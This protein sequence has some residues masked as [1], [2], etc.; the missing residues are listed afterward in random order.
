VSGGPYVI[1]MLVD[2]A[3][4]AVQPAMDGQPVEV[5]VPPGSKVLEVPSMTPDTY[6][7]IGGS[8][9]VSNPGILVW[10]DIQGAR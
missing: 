4:Y 7:Q 10:F 5:L 9:P 2:D 1:E 3:A 6:Y 8:N